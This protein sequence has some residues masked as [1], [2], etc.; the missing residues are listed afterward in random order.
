[1]IP[2]RMTYFLYDFAGVWSRHW[3][4]WMPP[5]ISAFKETC[6]AIPCNFDYPEDIRPSAVHGIWYF[7][8]PY[9]RNFPP[10][11][12]NSKTNSAHEI[13]MGRTK[14]IGDLQASN[15]TIQ[16][17]TVTNELQGKYYFRADLGGYNQYTY[18]EHANLY[19]LGALLGCGP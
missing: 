5:S 17:D 8:S 16:I 7:N 3:S 18:S 11:V 12:L 1:M 6:V 9:P 4:A 15:C 14:I 2:F 10:V 19:I 13:Y